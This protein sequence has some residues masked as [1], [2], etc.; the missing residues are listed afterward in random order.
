[1]SDDNLIGRPSAAG[2]HVSLRSMQEVAMNDRNASK[3]LSTYNVAYWGGNYYDVNELGHISVCP[4]PDVR[5]ARVD[6]AQL[7]K[8]MQLEQGQRLP[9]LFCF[10]QILQHRLRSINGAF[11]RARDSFGY[12]GDYFLVY[13]IKVNQHRRVIESLVNSGEPLGLEAG[14][15]AEMM[16][17]LAHAGM[18]RSV[19]VCNGYKDREYIRLA[20]IGEK[21]GHKVY[22]VIEK[23]SEIKMVLEEA[24]RLNVVPR[25]GVRARLASQ[26]SGK[27]QA[28]GGEKSKFGLSATQVLQLVDMLRDANSL[29]SLQLLH[30]HL[31]SQLSNIRDI[32]TGV[33]ESARFYVELHKLGVNIQCFDVGGGLGVDYEGTRS[34]SDCSVNYGLNEYA[35]NVIWG[36]GDAC[37]EH[38]LRHPTVITESGR[39]VTAH[40]TVLV[41][42]VIGV[43]RNEFNAPQAPATDAPRALESLWDTWLEMQ[44]PENRRS[45][46]EW[47][48]D[49]Q[50][51]LHD[52]H[53]QYAHGMLDLKQR[54]WAEELYLSICNEIQ[55]QLDP[56]NRAHRPIID[57]LQERMA[58]K[59]YVNFSL[60][61]SMPDA[62][63]IDQLFPVLPLEGLNNPPERRAVLLDITCDSDGTIDH[64]IDGDGVATTM[65]M[66]PYDAENPPLLGFFMVGAY[67]EILGN[68]HNLFGDTAAVDVLVHKDGTVEVK[69]TDEGDTV[70][71]MLEYVQLNPEKLLKQFHDQV[72]E[73]DLDTKLQAQ[74]MEEFEAGLYG[75]TYLEDE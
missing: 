40:H 72:K 35:N 30:F 1:M 61:Q 10:P 25:L 60:F 21:L 42:N 33:R 59:L 17:V 69:Q 24:E 15:K 62:W 5:E 44:E 53:T 26:G 14:S 64:Y 68:M 73:T 13:P 58:D 67:Q 9:A 2:A 48:H 45:L 11:K 12:E 51:D 8:R 54:A 18:T 46:R 56:S 36:I 75:Y 16:A 38:G 41:S 4:D 32:S 22:L 34:Q 19:I 50:M 71:D 37:N 57:E 52:V 47:L 43:E 27:W 31:G 65:P 3:M 29:D 55:K 70:A 39:A 74:F 20:L 49:S 6:L 66:P 7:V 63:G 23:M 28:S